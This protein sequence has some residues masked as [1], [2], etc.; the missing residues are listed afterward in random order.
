MQL[1]MAFW[2][3]L[4]PLPRPAHLAA[5]TKRTLNPYRYLDTIRRSV[6]YS[7]ACPFLYLEPLVANPPATRY[8]SKPLTVWAH[9]VRVARWGDP[10]A[11]DGVTIGSGS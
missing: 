7:E 4:L 3:L 8:C 1:L 10:N 5:S 9:Q 6:D 2:K 11:N